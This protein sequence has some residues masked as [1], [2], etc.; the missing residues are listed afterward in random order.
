MRNA[1]NTVLKATEKQTQAR[2][3]E[4]SDGARGI[5]DTY[6]PSITAQTLINELVSVLYPCHSHVKLYRPIT[7][8]EMAAVT[9][10]KIRTNHRSKENILKMLLHFEYLS[11]QGKYQR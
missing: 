2:N 4:R 7:V 3:R 5:V 1:W 9:I 10:D 6:T 8:V 11:G